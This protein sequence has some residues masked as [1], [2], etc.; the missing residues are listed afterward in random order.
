MSTIF[1][2]DSFLKRNYNV[3]VTI[4]AV[5]EGPRRNLI[6]FGKEKSMNYFGLIFSFMVPGIIAGGMAATLINDAVRRRRIAS[7]KHR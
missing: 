7:R 6:E 5:A 4:R 3:T 1:C 2:L